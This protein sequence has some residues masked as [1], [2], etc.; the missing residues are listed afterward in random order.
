MQLLMRRERSINLVNGT[1]SESGVDQFLLQ[2]HVR[3]RPTA[4]VHR[5]QSSNFNSKSLSYPVN[6]LYSDI[7]FAPFG[8]T[9]SCSVLD[10][11]GRFCK[12]C[13]DP[14]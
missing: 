2:I 7:R 5:E 6:I 13:I 9:L 14:L 1:K 8:A 10:L 4:S 12:S 11:M 3:G